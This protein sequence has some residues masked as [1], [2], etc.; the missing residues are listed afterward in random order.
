MITG[1]GG[2]IYELARQNNCRPDE[3]IDMSSNLNPLGPPPGLL[4]YLQQHIAVIKRLPDAGA[5][6][7]I[8]KFEALHGLSPGRVLAGHGTTEFIY[9]IT[10]SLD[11]KNALILGPTYADYRDSCRQN[12]TR[13]DFLMAEESTGF[14][15]D[16]NQIA[17]AVKNRDMVFVCNPNNPTGTMLPRQSIQELCV[18]CPNTFF[19]VDESYLPFVPEESHISMIRSDLENLIVLTSMSK[20]FSIP[21]LRTGFLKAS[22]AVVE[23]CRNAQVPWNVNSLAQTAVDYLL[24]REKEM[25]LFI[26]ATRDYIQTEMGAFISR[27]QEVSAF[28]LLPGPLPYILIKNNSHLTADTVCAFLAKD[29]ILIRNCANFEGLSENYIRVALKDRSANQLLADKLIELVMNP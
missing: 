19:V 5:A 29:N 22:P 24:S 7:L 1:H 15:H 2:N 3:I 12:K 18:S 8:E 25:N 10:R 14:S 6:G 4:A 21:G 20:I 9:A 27:F 26:Q 13:F 28:S 16:T 17:A 23:Q 11:I